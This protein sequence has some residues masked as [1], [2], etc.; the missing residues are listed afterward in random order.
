MIPLPL[1]KRVTVRLGQPVSS[2]HWSSGKN[3]SALSVRELFILFAVSSTMCWTSMFVQPAWRRQHQSSEMSLQL[4]V[5]AP[6]QPSQQPPRMQ[7]CLQRRTTKPTIKLGR[8]VHC[9]G[10]W[11][12]KRDPMNCVPTTNHGYQGTC[13]L[14]A[15]SSCEKKI[16]HCEI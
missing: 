15:L 12:T 7:D 6:Q 4:L 2:P 10:E 3:T 16:P 13:R 9:V 11:I 5:F 8:D 14:G 1:G